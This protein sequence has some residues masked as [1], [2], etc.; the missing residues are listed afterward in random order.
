MGQTLLMTSSNFK[1]YTFR[2]DSIFF[3]PKDALVRVYNH[4]LSLSLT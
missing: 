2:Q 1:V 3:P 4:I